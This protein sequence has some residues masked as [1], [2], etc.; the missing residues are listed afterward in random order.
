[1]KYLS[2]SLCVC[3]RLCEIE[4]TTNDLIDLKWYDIG[5]VSLRLNRAFGERHGMVWRRVTKPMRY[6][7]HT[8]GG[9]RFTSLSFPIL[10]IP[11]TLRRILDAFVYKDDEGKEWAAFDY[12]HPN[13]I[14]VIWGRIRYGLVAKCGSDC[15]CLVHVSGSA[16]VC[17]FIVGICMLFSHL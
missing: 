5:G 1:M 3:V 17:L 8:A 2:V 9:C 16:C 10:P 7:C 11:P 6:N 14:S 12:K 13:H 15:A 4:M